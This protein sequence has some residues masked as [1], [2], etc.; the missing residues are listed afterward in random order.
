MSEVLLYTHP[1]QTA[2]LLGGLTRPYSSLGL[3]SSSM[4]SLVL[5]R[6]SATVSPKTSPPPSL[7]QSPPTWGRLVL[8]RNPA[9]P[10]IVPSEHVCILHPNHPNQ[11]C[12]VQTHL[13]NRHFDRISGRRNALGSLLCGDEA[14]SYLRLIN[15]CITQL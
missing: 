13:P 3:S 10:R 15:F 2:G 11:N 6:V 4:T 5:E 9:T 12:S 8:A 7:P 14:G 1:H